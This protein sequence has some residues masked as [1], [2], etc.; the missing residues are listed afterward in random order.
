MHTKLHVTAMT[1]K[2][3]GRSEIRK[4]GVDGTRGG[5]SKRWT[6]EQSWVSPC[7]PWCPSGQPGQGPEPWLLGPQV[8]VP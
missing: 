8:P 3:R 5:V 6:V 1:L 2:T 4:K 7:Q